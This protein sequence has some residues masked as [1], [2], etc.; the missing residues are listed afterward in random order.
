MSPAVNVRREFKQLTRAIEHGEVAPYSVDAFR[1]AQSTSWI[2]AYEP[3]IG[4]ELSTLEF[5]VSPDAGAAANMQMETRTQPQS[6]A[7]RRRP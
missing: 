1:I 7:A 5:E 3:E 6:P 2:Q 4:M